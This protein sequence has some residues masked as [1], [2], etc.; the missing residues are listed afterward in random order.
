MVLSNWKR[1]AVI[2]AILAATYVGLIASAPMQTTTSPWDVDAVPSNLMDDNTA[3]VD[4]DRTLQHR[5]LQS[6]KKLDVT[7]RIVGGTAAQAN[8]SYVFS[9]GTTLCGGTLIAPEYV[10]LN[11]VFRCFM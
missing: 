6:P 4:T 1:A 9:A 10:I 2:A 11:A 7:D 5:L 3:T 8:P